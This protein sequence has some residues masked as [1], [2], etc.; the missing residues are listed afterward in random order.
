VAKPKLGE[1]LKAKRVL[2]DEQLRTVL[3]HQKQWGLSFGRAAAQAGL[4]SAEQILE[5]LAEQLA[6]PVIDLDQ[7]EMDRALVDVIPQK[8]AE[9]HQVVPVRVEG[10]RGEVLVVAMA[11]PAAFPAQDA[12]LAVSRKQRLKVMLAHDEGIHRAIGRLFRGD[13]LHLMGDVTVDAREHLLDLAAEE[14]S[15][16]PAG[17][18]VLQHFNLSPTCLTVIKRAMAGHKIDSKQVIEKVLEAWALRQ[19]QGR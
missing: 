16:I 11:A 12:V 17:A 4:C 8:I 2:N 3:S 9:Q 19:Q 15:P 6:L 13:R 5:A 1:I 18:D 14:N 10:Q 7:L